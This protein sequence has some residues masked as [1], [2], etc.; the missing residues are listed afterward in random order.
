E[1]VHAEVCEDDCEDGV[2]SEERGGAAARDGGAGPGDCGG[3]RSK[4]QEDLEQAEV[5]VYL[6]R[7]SADNRVAL[8]VCERT[9]AS[10]RSPVAVRRSKLAAIHSKRSRGEAQKQF[11]SDAW[12]ASALLRLGTREPT[13]RR[14]L[15]PSGKR[16]MRRDRLRTA[17][18]PKFA[19]RRRTLP[20]M[21]R[22]RGRLGERG[23]H[24]RLARTAA[25]WRR[26]W[27]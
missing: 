19:A 6:L 10:R 15:A 7:P 13:H 1:A 22:Q 12:A 8:V 26:T 9:P 21:V 25:A 24:W 4:K 2:R 11:N 20:P 14:A 16:G 23:P 17:K 27:R 18:Q 3:D 5:H